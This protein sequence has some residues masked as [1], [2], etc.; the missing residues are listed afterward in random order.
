[1]KQVVFNV[2]EKRAD[3][4]IEK[5]KILIGESEEPV[6]VEEAYNPQD[7]D[8]VAIF[9]QT[10]EVPYIGIFKEWYHGTNDKIV[11]HA[12]ITDIAILEAEEEYWNADRMRP[13]TDE[14]K[15]RLIKALAKDGRKWNCDTKKFEDCE[16]YE[17]IRT[18]DD[19]CDDLKKRA[20][21]GDTLA[22]DLIADLQFNSPRTPDLLAFIKLRII[23]YAINDGWEPKFT[24]D[25]YRYYPWFYLYTKEEIAKMSDDKRKE[26]LIVGGLAHS[27][28]LCGLAS[29]HSYNGFSRSGASIGARLAFY[30]SRRAKYAGRQFI[31]LYSALNFKPV[32]V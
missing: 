24:K 7:G 5:L 4:I 17:A 11:C 22:S 8:F 20:E 6:K 27:G 16:P 12:H 19:A 2:P 26:L 3:E 31:E 30:D 25:E 15:D 1:M 9:D 28:A 13:A 21:A 23:V 14:E 29:S 32:E 10:T 18:F